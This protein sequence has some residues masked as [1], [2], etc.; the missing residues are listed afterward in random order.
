MKKLLL[1][2]AVMLTTVSAWAQTFTLLKSTD[3]NNPEHQYL[4]KNG[5]NVFMDAQTSY[6]SGEKVNGR[7]AFFAY[8]DNEGDVLIYS[9][10]AN[11]WVSYT[12]ADSYS[13]TRDFAT[14]VGDR[15]QANPWRFTVSVNQGV[16]VYQFAPHN[17]TNIAS[18]YMNWFEGTA[19]DKVQNTVGLYSTNASG[20]NGSAWSLWPLTAQEC[21]LRDVDGA[22]LSLSKL[23]QDANKYE[24][25]LATLSVEPTPLYVTVAQ[26]GR[27]Q[28]HTAADGG[29]YLKQSSW[30]GWNSQ[31]TEGTGD[32]YWTIEN[33]TVAN[34]KYLVLKNTSASNGG[35]LG[36]DN[37]TDGEPLYVNTGR[38][39]QGVKLTVVDAET[40]FAHVTYKLDYKGEDKGTEEY[41]MPV[42]GTFQKLLFAKDYIYAIM[43]TGNVDESWDGKTY[44]VNL[45]D[46]FPFQVSES[47]ENAHWYYLIL[48]G[49]GNANNPPKWIATSETVP[50][51]NNSTKIEGDAGQWAF[52]GNPFDGIKVLNKASGATQTLGVDAN[53]NVIMQDTEKQWIIQQGNG[54]FVLLQEQ[55]TNKYVHDLSSELK[56]WDNGSAKNDNGSAFTVKDVNAWGYP[57]SVTVGSKITDLSTI[58]D[59]QMVVFKN[60]NN[61]KYVTLSYDLETTISQN[62]TGLSVF[63]LHVKDAQEFKYTI[64]SEREGYYFPDITIHGSQDVYM[65]SSDSPN[66][67]Q[68]LT[69]MTDGTTLSD[70]QFVIK[71]L[72]ANAGYFDL[73][74]GTDFC[75]WQGKGANSKY[76]I[77][78][79]TVNGE[80]CQITRNAILTETNSGEIYQSNYL[81]FEGQEPVIAGIPV[82]NKQNVGS[83][84]TADIAIPLPLS[85][86]GGM[87][88]ATMI[89]NFDEDKKWIA[90]LEDGI[91]NVKCFDITSIPTFEEFS[92][93]SWAIYPNFDNGHFTFR[94]KNL[95]I[96][97]YITLN[98]DVTA[99]DTKG[100]VTLTDNPTLLD[101][102][103]WHTDYPCFRKAGKTLY[104]TVNS[105][106]DTDV[107]L[108]TYTGG[109]NNHEGNRHFFTTPSFQTSITDAKAATLYTPVAV[110]IP[111]GV[112]AKYV[113]AEGENMGSTGKLVYTKLE[114]I[115][116]AN[117]AVVL[118][119]EEGG[120]TF[121]ATTEAGEEVTDNVLFGYATETA[122]TD[123]TGIYA[124]ANKTNGVAF[125]PFAGSTYKAGKAYLNIA[126]LNASEVRL[127]NI[128][129]EG[130]ETGIESIET[131]NAKAEIYDL[132]G[133]RVQK[134]Q[135]GLY[136]VNGKKVIK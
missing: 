65:E 30:V 91:Y 1:L 58:T 109:N 81:C 95:A 3:V 21:Y 110:T 34:V 108:S 67:Y 62:P 38:D 113:K 107:Y 25:T 132:A 103:M 50:Y 94:I 6:V 66:Q 43:P 97:K 83:T 99:F 114:N 31:V 14:L 87:T 42:G 120:Y 136:I 82:S 122:A 78:P 44:K 51:P 41:Y 77:Y 131:E 73:N 85:K 54:G 55:A 119:G 32:F 102:I 121:T 128:F 75:G 106:G 112:T 86:E 105:P 133:R 59:G 124:L 90:K 104:L 22:Y 74:A 117:S 20:D 100:T 84:F 76:E 79:V 111:E 96:G 49:N 93:G 98:S 48:R 28:I 8:G 130:E 23:G 15:Q 61:N 39:A 40:D 135:K 53:S 57:S 127:F 16:S 2:F 101:M 12:K 45:V 129:D 60:V 64:E 125:Y 116:P 35:Y 80:I 69:T 10:D 27:W 68:I 4:M 17:N 33:V 7:F 72:G 70:G 71:S 37:H 29:N 115:I 24:S 92:A 36:A 52:V 5:N 11:K 18:R 56:I 19:N 134:A 89:S 9:I 63:K 26:D 13:N 88:N 118:T 126:D 123:K 46:N 47:F